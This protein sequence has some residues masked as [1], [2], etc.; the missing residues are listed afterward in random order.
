MLAESG[1]LLGVLDCPAMLCAAA[2]SL[3]TRD[4]SLAFAA[5]VS[6]G[7]GG[8]GGVGGGFFRKENRG[9]VPPNDVLLG[10]AVVFAT[11]S[12]VAL[13]LAGE[14]TAFVSAAIGCGW[15]WRCGV[16]PLSAPAALVAGVG[17]VFLPRI[18]TLFCG[19]GVVAVGTSVLGVGAGV[20]APLLDTV[21]TCRA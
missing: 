16:L 19:V 18:R 8:L 7:A 21:A 20:T 4:E 12:F 3:P 11:V 13:A 5:L 15:D 14:A 6:F 17:A 10:T 1:F 9:D 2:V